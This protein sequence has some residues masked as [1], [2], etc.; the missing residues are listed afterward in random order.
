MS[1]SIDGHTET[2]SPTKILTGRR[3]MLGLGVAGAT[4]AVWRTATESSRSSAVS[5]P[6]NSDPEATVMTNGA[7]HSDHLGDVG[8]LFVDHVYG[9]AAGTGEAH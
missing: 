3:A 1:S 2:N 7:R 8:H 6:Y 4:T 5:K 9:N